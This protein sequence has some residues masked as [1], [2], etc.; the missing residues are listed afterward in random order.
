MSDWFMAPSLYPLYLEVTTKSRH[1][2]LF[3]VRTADRAD[4]RAAGSARRPAHAAARE[5]VQVQVKDG[6]A[7][8]AAFVGHDAIT[9]FTKA[10]P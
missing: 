1:S 8:V 9:A 5:H 3:G 7:G 6:L 2:G 4:G 10:H